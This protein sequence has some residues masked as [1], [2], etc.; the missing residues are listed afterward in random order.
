MNSPE[1]APAP[2]RASHDK[3]PDGTKQMVCTQLCKGGKASMRGYKEIDAQVLQSLSGLG[4]VPQLVYIQIRN[5][6]TGRYS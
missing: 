2:S 5:S 4:H 6:H 1:I 3:A